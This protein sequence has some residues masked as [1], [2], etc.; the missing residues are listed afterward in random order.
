V[1]LRAFNQL[2][3]EKKRSTISS[4]QP[5]QRPFNK[6]RGGKSEPSGFFYSLNL[7]QKTKEG[8]FSTGALILM[9]GKKVDKKRKKNMMLC[10]CQVYYSQQRGRKRA[11]SVFG[12]MSF[13]KKKR[14][15][16]KRGEHLN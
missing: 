7:K 11:V 3:G 9:G 10:L 8:K 12:T 14:G 13:Q 4:G 15:K 16:K 2:G 5:F 6:K 1:Q